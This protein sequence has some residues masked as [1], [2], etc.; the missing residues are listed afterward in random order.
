MKRRKIILAL[1]VMILGMQ[2]AVWA[3]IHAQ[4]SSAANGYSSS[5]AFG[6]PGGLGVRVDTPG[7]FSQ[8]DAVTDVNADHGK[9]VPRLTVAGAQD[10]VAMDDAEPGEGFAA[11]SSSHAI[12]S[13]EPA[14]QSPA[15][16]AASGNTAF[17][18]PGVTSHA[19]PIN[20]GIFTNQAVVIPNRSNAVAGGSAEARDLTTSASFV[21]PS[22]SHPAVVMLLGTAGMVFLYRRGKYRLPKKR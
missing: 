11:G 8:A 19:T 2:N 4:A 16:E 14:A 20:R 1:S 10:Q 17:S 6:Q 7:L 15:P 12:I 18:F 13:W 9:N 3:D 22:V 21:L 5:N